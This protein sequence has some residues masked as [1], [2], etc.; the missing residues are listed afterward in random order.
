MIG[1]KIAFETHIVSLC[2][3]ASGKL[4]ALETIRK[5]HVK[6]LASSFVDSQSNYCAI[7]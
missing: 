3:K 2:K 7:V 4:W 6:D 5:F 1:N